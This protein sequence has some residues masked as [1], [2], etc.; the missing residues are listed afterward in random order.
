MQNNFS[1]ETHISTVS[2]LCAQKVTFADRLMWTVVERNHGKRSEWMLTSSGTK[3]SNKYVSFPLK[4]PKRQCAY[5]RSCFHIWNTVSLPHAF[6][7]LKGDMRWKISVGNVGRGVLKG[8]D[9]IW[10]RQ[11]YSPLSKLGQDSKFPM[12]KYYGGGATS[13]NKNS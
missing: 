7:V 2:R 10:T 12:Q 6:A 1:S 8:N 3:P 11:K 13:F 4:T 5:V 9:T